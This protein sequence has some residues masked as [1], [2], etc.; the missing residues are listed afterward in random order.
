[1]QQIPKELAHLVL[2]NGVKA[3]RLHVPRGGRVVLVTNGTGGPA[4][5]TIV[6]G[7]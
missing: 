3:V 7:P 6:T 4:F 1:M 5:Y 2:L